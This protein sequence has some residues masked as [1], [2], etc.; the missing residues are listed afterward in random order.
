M[1]AQNKICD[2]LEDIKEA[3]Q[4]ILDKINDEARATLDVNQLKSAQDVIDWF[5][6]LYVLV[7]QILL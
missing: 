7:R 2:A 3:K 1:G 4:N 5:Q 6:N